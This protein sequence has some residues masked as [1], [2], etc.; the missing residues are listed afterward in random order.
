MQSYLH[1][2]LQLPKSLHD[3]LVLRYNFEN[4]NLIKTIETR[5]NPKGLCSI[6]Y[7]DDCYIS[8][9]GDLKGEINITKYKEDSI[10]IDSDQVVDIKDKNTPFQ[11][12]VLDGLQQGYK[13][14]CN[15][16]YGQ[17]GAMTGQF[18]LV[19]LA[20]ATTATG[21]E[22][23]EIA[24]DKTLEQY[25]GSKLVYGD[26]IVGDEPLLLQKKYLEKLNVNT[27]TT[28]NYYNVNNINHI[29]NLKLNSFLISTYAFSEIPL[30]LQ[31]E[32]TNKVLNIYVSHGF[33]AWNNID[34]YNFIENKNITSEREFPLTGNKNYYVKFNPL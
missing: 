4:L 20:A 30:E 14:V 13:L 28:I 9:P 3:F 24:R 17:V 10:I 5:E 31:K 29:Q 33:I 18:T 34:I 21:R 16:V 1:F 27:M 23:L 8:Y 12:A 25:K 11:K 2:Y 7:N 19:Q 22:M 6:T 15:S 26:S 32:Y